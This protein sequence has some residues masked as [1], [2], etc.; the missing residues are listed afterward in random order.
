MLKWSLE[1]IELPLKVHWASPE[2]NPSPKTNFIV[3][4]HDNERTGMGEAALDSTCG[5]TGELIEECFSCF[6]SGKN[7]TIDGLEELTNSVDEVEMPKGLRFG[8]ESA[9]IHYL[10]FLNESSV[11]RI[12]C[13]NQVKSLPISLSVPSMKPSSFEDFYKK[14][15][16][17]RF[18]FL[19]VKVDTAESMA[20]VKKIVEF[21]K[22][23]IRIDANES[24]KNP[25]AVMEMFNEL[26]GIPIEFLERPM[27]LSLY[28][29]LKELKKK[30]PVPIIAGESVCPGNMTR[31][32]K[33]CFDGVHVK[34]MKSGGYIKA[35]NQM[36]EAKEL[37]MKV[38]LGDMV[39]TGLGISSAMNI[40][41]R[42]DYFDL[43]GLLLLEKDPYPLVT[44]ENGHIFYSFVH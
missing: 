30:S 36:R 33:E 35:L 22:G 23:K 18:K 11:Q 29:A 26:E 27:P 25:N 1:K 31:E 10:A 41:D 20:L 43:D 4:V 21:H 9:Y 15:T 39:E 2:N 6:N 38:L 3:K 17:D 37:G 5:E 19:K 32:L 24:F 7:A 28:E 8:I 12:L 16:L 42:A 14:Y 13:L 34:L 44:E 40:A